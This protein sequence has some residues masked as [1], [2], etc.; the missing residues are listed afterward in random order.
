VN[1]EAYRGG[2]CARGA[3]PGPPCILGRMA[4]GGWIPRF[5][6]TLLAFG[7]LVLV[8]AGCSSGTL[9]GVQ[10]TCRSSGGLFA[11][12]KVSCTGS[13]DSVRGS[14]TLGIV[15]VDDDLDGVYRLDATIT[16]GR[17]TAKAF[18]TDTDGEE[19]GGELAPDGPL[20]I[21]AL[22]EPDEDED[23]EV[24]LEVAEGEK[25]EGLS[26]EARLVPQE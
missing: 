18:V 24:A 23:V 25:V 13:V 17:G 1:L 6:A 19:V 9:V 5:S 7:C 3:D 22:V 11:Q 21:T 2:P 16:V 4:G 20:R 8:L 12:Q 15:E 26:Y 10:Q 14:P